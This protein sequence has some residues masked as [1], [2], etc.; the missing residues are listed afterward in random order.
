MA[1]RLKVLKKCDVKELQY[2]KRLSYDCDDEGE[3]WDEAVLSVAKKRLKDK[4]DYDYF[5]TSLY[6]M[7]IVNTINQ[8]DNLLAIQLHNQYRLDE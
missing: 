7:H 5:E 8:L 2:A 3:A 6:P 1:D 4:E